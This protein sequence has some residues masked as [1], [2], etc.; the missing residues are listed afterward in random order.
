LQAPRSSQQSV[1]DEAL[2]RLFSEL[3]SWSFD[4]FQINDENLPK[5]TTISVDSVDSF[6]EDVLQVT[7]I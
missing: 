7:A 4:L 3:G 6:A 2:E 5:A 1:D